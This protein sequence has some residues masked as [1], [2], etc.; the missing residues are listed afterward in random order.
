[1]SMATEVATQPKSWTYEDYYALSDEEQYEVIDG[2][3]LPMAPGPDMPHQDWVLNLATLLKLHVERRNLGRIS[4]APRD[5][6]LDEENIVQPDVAFVSVARKSI[7]ERRGIFGAPDIVIEILSPFSVR[8]D[9]QIKKELYARFGVKEFW[10]VDP[11]NNG[12]EIL[13]LE[14]GQ[15][16]LI[17]SAIGKGKVHSAIL[18]LEFEVAEVAPKAD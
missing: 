18:D 17:S 6:I 2:E 7:V 8:R 16:K 15:Y 4:L 9:R 13:A 12:V 14:S 1:M 5:V 3:L 10:I 11:G